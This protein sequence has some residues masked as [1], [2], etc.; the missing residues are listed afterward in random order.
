MLQGT[1]LM[2]LY[3]HTHQMRKDELSRKGVVRGLSFM[4]YINL[5]FKEEKK[6]RTC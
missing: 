3:N 2:H 6:R 5:S 1:H 4:L